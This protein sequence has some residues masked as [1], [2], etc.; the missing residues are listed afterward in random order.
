MK[1][2]RI[3]AGALCASILLPAAQAMACSSDLTDNKVGDTYAAVQNG[4][5]LSPPLGDLALDLHHMKLYSRDGKEQWGDYLFYIGAAAQAGLLSIDARYD[6]GTTVSLDDLA[7]GRLDKTRAFLALRVK[8]TDSG[9][10]LSQRTGVA[11]ADQA[12]YFYNG[13]MVVDGVDGNALKQFGSASFRVVTVHDHVV[14]VPE[15]V[16]AFLDGAKAMAKNYDYK[17]DLQA[18]V[19][20]HVAKPRHE[21]ALLGLSPRTCTWELIAVDVAPIGEKYTTHAVD[22]ALAQIQSSGQEL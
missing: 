8:R 10:A 9:A 12:F 3:L 5:F 16:D 21:T 19:G 20:A 4:T 6:D 15:E 18:W 2:S 13:K 17:L 11:D 7:A 14:D 1:L 22:D